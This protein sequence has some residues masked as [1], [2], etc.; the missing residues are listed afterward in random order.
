MNVI[1][2]EHQTSPT[3]SL[4]SSDINLLMSKTH[5]SFSKSKMDVGHS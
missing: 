2:S 1:Y 3:N 4:H 5:G